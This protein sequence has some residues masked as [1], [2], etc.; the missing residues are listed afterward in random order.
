MVQ[1]FNIAVLMALFILLSACSSNDTLMCKSG[2]KVNLKDSCTLT[3]RI[4]FRFDNDKA[5]RTFK[6][7]EKEMMFALRLALRNHESSKLKGMG[8]RNVINAI[9]SISRQLLDKK[10]PKVKITEYT[11]SDNTSPS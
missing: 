3:V 7:K 6:F 8:K 2:T 5:M 9:K 11:F 1:K 4:E 10:T